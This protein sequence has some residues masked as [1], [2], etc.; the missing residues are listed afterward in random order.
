MSEQLLSAAEVY[1]DSLKIS[2]RKF[3]QLVKTGQIKVVR[4]GR[5]LRV[6]PSELARFIRQQSKKQR[7]M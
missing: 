4:I 6:Q 2:R 5:L 7:G 1:E 3:Y